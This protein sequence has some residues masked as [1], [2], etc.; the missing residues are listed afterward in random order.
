MSNKPYSKTGIMALIFALVV[1]AGLGVYYMSLRASM[2][3]ATQPIVATMPPIEGATETPATAPSDVA[4]QAG[5]ET[6]A[7]AQSAE[8]DWNAAKGER[9]IGDI[10]APVKIV[11][12]SSLTCPHCSHFHKDTLKT[13]KETYI[14]TG[15]VYLEF[16]DFPLNAPALQG[17]M[18]ARCLPA[19]RYYPFVQL[20]FETQDKWAFED[21]YMSYLKQNAQLAGLSA[22]QIDV[23]LNNKELQEFIAGRMEK[24]QAEN[25]VTSTPTFIVDGTT[26]I[27]GAR[28]MDEFTKAIEA[29]LAKKN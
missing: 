15:K 27:S 21:D 11:E 24:A 23:C 7:T 16:V 9:G 28:P 14:D 19:E 2:T 5:E 17:S 26:T 29:E 22:D 1:F 8:I 20:L 4:P 12:Y 18:L 25:S 10:N 6:P 3:D 13:L